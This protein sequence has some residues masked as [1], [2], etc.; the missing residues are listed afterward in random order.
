MKPTILFMIPAEYESLVT[1]GVDNMIIDRDEDGFF[2]RCVT[3]H[4]LTQRTQTIDI[5]ETHVIHEIGFD[6][7]PGSHRHKLLRYL[8]VPLH[9]FRI[10]RICGRLVRE[11]QVDLIR[12]TDPY[13][14]G[15][16]ALL[17]ARKRG[18]PFCV[19]IHSDYDKRFELDGKLGAPTI[20]GSRKLAK[21]LERFVLS[22]ADLVMPIRES[23]GKRAICDG[24]RS[25][26]VR[27]IPHG[28]DL[29]PFSEEA[30]YDIY[31]MFG[32]DRHKKILSFVG[33]LS[34]ENYV[35][36]LLEMARQLSLQREDFILVFAGG[37]NEEDRL[38]H[39]VSNEPQLE[40]TVR[41]LGF[42]PREVC[43][44]LRRASEVNLCLMAG[45]S[46]IEACAS[47]RP[48]ISYDVE[49][50]YELVRNGETG[51]LIKEHDNKQL[52]A[53]VSYLLDHPD[54]AAEMGKNAR[55]LALAKHDIR[56][57]LEIKRDCYRELLN[58]RR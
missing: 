58:D 13:W 18:L 4:P 10:L 8:Q 12:A 31:Q 42:Q 57:T 49:W 5:N 9:F 47:E 52:V 56:I 39:T 34:N 24:A 35:D 33:R 25:E 20:L 1:K 19:S 22:R 30:S 51:F 21:R 48:V 3:V 16:F 2:K 50:H 14:M 27:I 7:I 55:D 45:F 40:K 38:R 54:E 17:V 43:I 6:L 32:I 53:A 44:D 23:L 37:G 29:R 36:D 15:F 46:L 11:E 28:I 41:M 26:L